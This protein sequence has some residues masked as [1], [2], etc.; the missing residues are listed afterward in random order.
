MV[1]PIP[2]QCTDTH[3]LRPKWGATSLW[4]INDVTDQW[5][6][7]SFFV[8]FCKETPLLFYSQTLQI[9]FKEHIQIPRNQTVLKISVLTLYIN[10]EVSNCHSNL[11]NFIRSFDGT[12]YM[13]HDTS[14]YITSSYIT[15]PCGMTLYVISQ[16]F[17]VA[18]R[19]TFHPWT[20]GFIPSVSPGIYPGYSSLPQ[21]K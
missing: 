13:I 16:C 10:P 1:A 20:V 19:F 17:Y 11:W 18:V 9:M 6:P 3:R 4:L 15:P 14:P 2:L 21:S 12:W 8:T 7:N 5:R